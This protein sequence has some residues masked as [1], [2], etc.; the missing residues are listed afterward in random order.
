MTI[1]LYSLQFFT[2]LPGSAMIPEVM[3]MI[4]IRRPVMM[5]MMITYVGIIVE[6]PRFVDRPR[7]L[8]PQIRIRTTTSHPPKHSAPIRRILVPTTPRCDGVAPLWSLPS[9]TAALSAGAPADKSA[10]D[11][12]EDED[13]IERVPALL[14]GLRPENLR[15]ERGDRGNHDEEE[16]QRRHDDGDH[17]GAG[18]ESDGGGPSQPSAAVVV[19]ATLSPKRRG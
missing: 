19:G 7:R 14:H 11:G 17:D 12:E 13:E 3:M 2:I 8:L 18:V 9:L 6:S 16:S 10:D 15:P 1:F 5:M 4:G